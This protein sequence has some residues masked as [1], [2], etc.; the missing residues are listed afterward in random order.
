MHLCLHSLFL[1]PKK[2]LVLSIN[3]VLCYFSPSAILQR[4][5]KVFRKDVDE[6]K[7]EVRVRM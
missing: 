3:G 5:V 1:E 7:V 4:N 2:L 6:T